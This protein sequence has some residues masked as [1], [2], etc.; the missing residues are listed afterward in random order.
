L[1]AAIRP[2]RIEELAE[3]FA[4]EFDS[5]GGP[6]FMEGWR[7][8]DPEDAI[9]SACSSLI[10]VI[11]VKDSKIVQFSHF[12]V[13]EFLT[14]ARLAS[15][16]VGAVSRYHIPLGPAH[17]ILARACLTVLL[18]LDDKTDKKRLSG[19]PLAFYAAEHWVDH[20]KI[21]NVVSEIEDAMERLFDPT[22]QHLAAWNWIY[23]IFEQYQRSMDDLEEYPS[24][25]DGTPLFYAAL[26]GFSGLANYLINTH[27]ED[28][29]AECRH[30]Q[31]PL[32]AASYCGGAEV[33]QLLLHHKANVDARDAQGWTPLHVASAMGHTKVAQLLLEHGA[34]V[35]VRNDYKDTPLTLASY[36]GRSEVVQLLLVH[37]ADVH[38]KDNGDRTA[39]QW[40]IRRK[41]R[42]IAQLLSEHG[43]QEG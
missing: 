41:Y 28:I 33:V 14:S 3:I 11:N 31:T 10:V 20:A 2:L 32:R 24:P 25:P 40:A 9:L 21:E 35:N 4:I 6:K 5:N 8:E 30:H 29:G 15:S 26:C 7:P 13:K 19:F 17:A 37:R 43:C 18:Q 16:E 36:H 38:M 1:I 34:D 23:D 39:L 22:K 12:S 42:D 27:G